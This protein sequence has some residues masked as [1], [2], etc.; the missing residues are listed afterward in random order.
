LARY[1]SN[2]RIV[3]T[4][5]ENGAETSIKSDEGKNALDYADE[6]KELKGTEAYNLLRQKTPDGI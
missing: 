4:L 5:I 2:P 1:N 3:R 6:N